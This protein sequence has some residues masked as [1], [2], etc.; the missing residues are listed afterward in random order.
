MPEEPVA[1]LKAAAVLE[2]PAALTAGGRDISCNGGSATS[3]QAADTDGQGAVAR[4]DEV[5]VA[6]SKAS[7]ASIFKARVDSGGAASH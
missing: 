5:A 1:S 3:A 7:P 4:V 6:G 2:E